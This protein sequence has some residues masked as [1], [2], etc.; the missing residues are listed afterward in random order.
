MEVLPDEALVVHG[1]MNLPENFIK[2]TGVIIGKDGYM[3]GVSV[4]CAPAATLEDLTMP[5]AISAKT[6]AMSSLRP[7]KPIRITRRSEA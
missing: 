6:A 3:D 7:V 5:I 2:G 4:N 1:G